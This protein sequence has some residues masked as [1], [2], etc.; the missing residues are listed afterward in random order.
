MANTFLEAQGTSIGDSLVE[1]NL[2]GTAREVVAAARAANVQLELPC[3]AIIADA[4]SAD[5]EVRTLDLAFEGVPAGWRI[6]DIGPRTLDAYATALADCKTI[7]WNGPMGVFEMA[8]FAAGTIGL[9]RRIAA[10]DAV[11]IVGGGDTDAAIEQAG[12]QDRIT[13]I[14]TGGGASLEF[15][16]GKALP[17]VVAL[18]DAPP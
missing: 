8:P 5:A 9:A 11:S 15:I 3:D 7:F 4:F 13:H 16:E 6:L 14:S 10:L 1:H 2:I 12:V 18:Q 17:G